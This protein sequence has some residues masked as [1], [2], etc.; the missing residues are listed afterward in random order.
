MDRW[1]ENISDFGSSV[2]CYLLCNR[3]NLEFAYLEFVYTSTVIKF[4]CAAFTCG[5][6]DALFCSV[7]QL[8]SLVHLSYWKVWISP[9]CGNCVEL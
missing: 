7:S 9:D 1:L 3:D 5:F 2:D 8:E 4:T 6:S